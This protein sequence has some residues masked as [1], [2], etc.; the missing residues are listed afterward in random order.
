MLVRR[1]ALKQMVALA[2]APAI[3]RVAPLAGQSSDPIVAVREEINGDDEL[4]P[5]VFI[6]GYVVSMAD[7]YGCPFLVRNINAVPTRFYFG[8]ILEAGEERIISKCLR[9]FPASRG[10]RL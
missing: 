3:I 1:N 5:G 10:D 7:D 6:S 9:P 8:Q 2:V 4:M